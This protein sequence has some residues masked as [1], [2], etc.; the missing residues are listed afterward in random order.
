VVAAALAAGPARRHGGSARRSR[1]D[2]EAIA[3]FEAHGLP[4]GLAEL[5]RRLPADDAFA[6]LR[7][8][9]RRAAT[10]PGLLRARGAPPPDRAARR[11]GEAIASFE[12]HGLPRGL[13]EL[14]RRLPVDDAFA[15]LA[16]DTLDAV[17][18]LDPG[19][20]GLVAHFPLTK[21]AAVP[22]K[23]K[24][25][26]RAAPGRQR[27]LAARIYRLVL[28][29]LSLATVYGGDNLSWITHLST[30][31]AL[32]LEIQEGSVA[33]AHKRFRDDEAPASASGMRMALGTTGKL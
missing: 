28:A 29:E 33:M 7:R 9:R 2:R 4:R 1:G 13:A 22:T 5:L 10:R 17:L 30:D 21:L 32:C 25:A 18:R 11:V 16:C 8:P 23:F 26:R 15:P 24:L 14:L 12:A 20:F 31:E 3:S 6:P 27:A 19:Y